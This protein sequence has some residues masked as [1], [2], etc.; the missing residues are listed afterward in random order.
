MSALSACTPLCQK[1]ALDSTVKGF[2]EWTSG[3]QVLWKSSQGVLLSTQLSRQPLTHRI[4]Y[5]VS[6]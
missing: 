6:G 5:T 2:W 4:P 1:K 3:L